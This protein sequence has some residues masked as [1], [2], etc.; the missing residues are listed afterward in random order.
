[1]TQH[2]R[3]AACWRAFR[4]WPPLG[5]PPLGYPPPQLRSRAFLAGSDAEL[6]ALKSAFDEVFEQ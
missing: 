6:L 1:M 2:Y 4:L 3:A 5:Y